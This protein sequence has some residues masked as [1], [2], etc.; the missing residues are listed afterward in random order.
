[1][2]AAPA[3]LLVC[4]VLAGCQTLP[5]AVPAVGDGTPAAAAFAARQAELAGVGRWTLRGRS[6]LSAQDRGWNGTVHWR[7]SGEALELRFI[8][9]LGAGTLRLT[10]EPDR[11]RI[12]AS[13]GTDFVTADPAG[14][15]EQALGVALP[16]AALRWWVL[17]VPAP[18]ADVAA[19]DLDAAGRAT[20]FEQ[21]GWAVSYPRYT[22]HDGQILPGIVVAERDGARI[23]LIVDE[24][25][26]P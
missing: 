10:G 20:A 16:V 23:R 8:A 7:Q 2:R 22:D 12:E 3:L 1:M 19:L 6:A 13:D 14:D 25:G 18:A 26:A 9:P 4:T 24:W 21:D 17:G 15:L 11:M 5:T